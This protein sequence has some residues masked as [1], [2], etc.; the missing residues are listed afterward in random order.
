MR[1]GIVTQP[2]GRNYGGILQNYALQ[3][4]LRRM[5]HEPFT[6]LITDDRLKDYRWIIQDARAMMA[7]V[8]GQKVE[9]VLPGEFN[10]EHGSQKGMKRFI[11]K[12]ISCTR[13][14]T[15]FPV[16]VVRDYKLDVLIAGS[17]QI[18]RPKF[19]YNI[20]DQFLSFSQS[21]E[22]RKL[23][24]AA[25]FGTDQWEYSQPL[26]AKCTELARQF[27]GIS[28]R[29]RSGVE[30]CN[31][32]FGLEAEW[33]LDPTLLLKKEDYASFCR[34]KKCVKPYVLAYFLDFNP[35][36]EE[37][38]G[39][40]AQKKGCEVIYKTAD[41]GIGKDDS[42][43][44]WLSLIANAEAVLTD[45]YHGTIFSMLLQKEFWTIINVD[46]G[47]SRFHSLSELLPIGSR[48]V[49]NPDLITDTEL[50]YG[51]I[52]GLLDKKRQASLDWLTR[53]LR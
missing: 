29:E 4:V 43:E 20:E 48:I 34:Q 25:S 51:A 26:E 32:H 15:F 6:V 53:M 18:W 35:D 31:Q 41:S 42:I 30:L 52:S 14:Y 19:N 24:Y 10:K 12:N 36:T 8:T 33:V 1:I 22:V 7:W 40:F 17:D 28:V 46:R 13:T 23:A 11:K 2:L 49:D 44:S 50:D 21:R 39:R 27:H 37:R 47:A 16:D 9:F 45:S 3:Q 38:I 5:G